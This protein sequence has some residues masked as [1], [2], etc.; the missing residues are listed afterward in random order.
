MEWFLLAQLYLSSLEDKT[1]VKAVKSALKQFHR[2]SQRHTEDEKLEVL[3]LAY[4]Q[5]MERINGQQA[6]F[7]RLAMNV[8]FMDYLREEATYYRR[9]STRYFSGGKRTRA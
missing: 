9:A 7:R 3:S 8:L 5:I 4:K 2:K 1:T 6:G